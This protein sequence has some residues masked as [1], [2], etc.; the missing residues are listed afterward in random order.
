[1]DK[2]IGYYVVSFYNHRIKKVLY[3]NGE[4]WERFKSDPVINDEIES[5]IELR[6]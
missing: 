3:W 4:R 1:M 6:L 2:V 5:Y